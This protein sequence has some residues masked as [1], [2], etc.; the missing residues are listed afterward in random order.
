MTQEAT[1]DPRLTVVGASST[2]TGS[3]FG[4]AVADGTIFQIGGG[5]V[6]GF[7]VEA[8]K[9]VIVGDPAGRWWFVLLCVLGIA[10]VG[11][12]LWL[13]ARAAARVQVGIVVTAADTGR[14]AAR[15]ARLEEQAE[16]Y[17]RDTCAV[18]LKT[19]LRLPETRPWPREGIDALA[20]ETL[21]AVTMAE[22]LTAGA[23]RINLIP[24]MPLHTG[25]RFG[26]RIGHTH[27]RE[28]A[29]H[30]IRQADGAP[31]YF[32]ATTLRAVATTMEPLTV[33][34]LETVDG[35]DPS[36]VALALDL[37]GRGED[38]RQPVRAAC[39]QHGVGTLLLLRNTTDTL[40]ENAKTFGAVV[41]QT[42][43][44]W[45][46]APLPTAARNAHHAVFLSGPVAISIALGA[47]LAAA[48]PDRWTAYTFDNTTNTY[49]P[50]P[51]PPPS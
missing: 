24:T 29:V 41:E 15:A 25:F 12:G 45:R 38:F 50:F 27:A 22:R 18:T 48:H 47:R 4:R 42:C 9:S 1:N 5:L 40:E 17:S 30:A 19:G 6:T 23:T 49:E 8:A 11:L 28:I 14:G 3:A 21:T 33:E 43:R 35:G 2:P 31:A 13:R 37:Q 46:E 32:P 44:A 39:R 7:G 34:P 26:A 16:T 10:L 36:R 51:T 20:D